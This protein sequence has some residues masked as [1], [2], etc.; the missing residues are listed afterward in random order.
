VARKVRHYR[1]YI[2]D[3]LECIRKI[4]DYV[5]GMSF[6]EFSKDT[7]T[8]DAVV[9]N[10]EIIGEA[11]SQLPKKVKDK[12]P[13]IEWRS[14]IDF[15]NVIIHEYFGIDLEITWN[16]IKT[17]L[18]PLEEKIKHLLDILPGDENRK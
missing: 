16:I 7:K 12:Y 2:E 14:M 5:N 13:H 18:S 6:E 15:R 3:I 11:S 17:K 4:G 9:R 1:L 8:V 10:F